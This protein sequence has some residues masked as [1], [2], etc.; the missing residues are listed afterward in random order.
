MSNS[1]TLQ[2]QAFSLAETA[3]MMGRHRSWAYRQRDK[4]RIRTVKGLGRELVPASELE[5]I[6]T[7]G[8]GPK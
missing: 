2:R 4:G 1:K 5:R 6:L 7:G 3:E 8:D